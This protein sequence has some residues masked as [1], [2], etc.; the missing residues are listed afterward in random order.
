MKTRYLLFFIYSLILF[1]CQKEESEIIDDTKNPKPTSIIANSPLASLIAR[2]AQNPTALDNVID[3]SSCFSVQLP[4]TV[5]VNGINIVVESQ[6]DYQTV[7]NAIDAFST[8]DD[9]VN[10]V[11]PITLKFQNFSTQV[12][13]NSNALDTI[14]DNCGEDDGLDEIDCIA[15]NY[16]I[17]VNIYD[18]NNQI[19]NVLVIQNNTQLFS[20]ITSLSTGII[21]SIVYPIS[22][23]DSNGQSEIVNSN[24]E[25]ELFIENSVGD[26]DDS[27]SGLPVYLYGDYHIS[28]FYDDGDETSDYSTYTFTFFAAN[29]EVTQNGNVVSN[30]TWYKYINGGKD[31]I[32]LNFDNTNLQELVDDE[33]QVIEST[34][35]QTKLKHVSGGNGG[36]DY[37][38]FTKN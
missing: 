22:V 23:T 24:T 9:I 29:I 31:W 10:F 16:P 25:L 18:A 34:S 5:I 6:T 33:W 37:L 15:I 17:S 19:A 11:Y 21:G 7:Q 20:F 1:S 2:T 13:N 30:G 35:T 32:S 27:G 26:C 28:Y 36:T 12:V 14:I 8:D 4:V 38:Y 3:N